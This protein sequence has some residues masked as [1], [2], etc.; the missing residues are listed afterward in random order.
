MSAVCERQRIATTGA[1]ATDIACSLAVGGALQLLA[2][3]AALTT[4]PVGWGVFQSLGA[5]WTGYSVKAQQ[6]RPYGSQAVP[7]S[8]RVG[9]AC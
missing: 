1:C 6:D 9:G 8:C 3:V 4:G 2:V 5:L 7:D